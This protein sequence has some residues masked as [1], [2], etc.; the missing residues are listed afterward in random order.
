MTGNT[1]FFI[2]EF[3]GTIAFAISGVITSIEK[4]LDIFGR[5]IYPDFEGV[6]KAEF[7]ECVK[8]ELE[9]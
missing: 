4:K 3:V 2:C 9:K 5:D 6:K 8:I 7:Y 1:I